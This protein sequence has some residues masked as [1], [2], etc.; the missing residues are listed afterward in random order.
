LAVLTLR[1]D[2]E[3]QVW[4]CGRCPAGIGAGFAQQSEAVRHA[5][6]EHGIDA[7]VDGYGIIIDNQS[8][9]SVGRFAVGSWWD[10]S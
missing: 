6:M 10:L 1:V 8:R 7:K 3:S 2:F 9:E 4:W 5:R